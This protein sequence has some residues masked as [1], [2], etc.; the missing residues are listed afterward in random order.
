MRGE[1]FGPD[2]NRYLGGADL[3]G[4]AWRRSH[5]VRRKVLKH[6]PHAAEAP[7]EP[8]LTADAFWRLVEA[9]PEYAR[10]CYVTLA[11]TGLRV[12]EYLTLGLEHLRAETCATQVPGTKTA[13][14]AAVVAVDPDYWGWIVAAVPSPLAYQWLRLNFKKA[15]AEIG[16]S[17]LRLHDLRHL[18]AQLASDAGAPTAQVQAALRHA[19]PAM[20]RRYEKRAAKG[21]VA[22]LV[23]GALKRPRTA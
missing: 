16:R 12:G 6:F 17:D 8:E 7:R 21:E 2:T 4:D 18:F 19:N 10:P 15:A 3:Q 22:R 20:T 9:A 1:G 5:P 14:S 23:G 11:I 13:A